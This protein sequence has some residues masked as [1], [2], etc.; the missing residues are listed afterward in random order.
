VRPH[1]P[2]PR[3]RWGRAQEVPGEDPMLVSTYG[4]SFVRGL[5]GG[6]PPTGASCS[7][8]AAATLK[9]W[10]AYDLEGYI[11]RT[12]PQPRP[13][14]A[15]CDAL[16]G[17]QRWNFNALVNERDLHGFYA[18]PFVGT[19]ARSVMCAYSGVSGAPAC[20]SP[21][22]NDMLRGGGWDGHVVSGECLFL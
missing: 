20:G 13:P 8:R 12:D 14:S 15:R 11:P 2:Q 4:F 7:V 5:Q 17:C 9:H 3:S 6:A 10:V 21:L 16:G 22:L 1:K 19:E 18:A